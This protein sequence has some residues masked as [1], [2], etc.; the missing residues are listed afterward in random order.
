MKFACFYL[1]FESASSDWIFLLVL[2]GRCVNFVGCVTTINREAL[3]ENHASIP[4]DHLRI[5][6]RNLSF[7]ITKSNKFTLCKRSIYHTMI[8]LSTVICLFV[9]FSVYFTYSIPTVS[10]LRDGVDG[11]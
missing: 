5:A 10:I 1:E 11:V 4:S 2:T 3:F 6:Y 9:C 8:D 7:F